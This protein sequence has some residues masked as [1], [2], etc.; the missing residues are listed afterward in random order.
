MSDIKGLVAGNW[1]MNGLVASLGE[2]DALK[3]PTWCR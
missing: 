3:S 2:A 1:K